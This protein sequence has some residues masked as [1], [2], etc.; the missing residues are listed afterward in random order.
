MDVTGPILLELKTLRHMV[1]FVKQPVVYIE[2][3]DTNSMIQHRLDSQQIK[4][5]E[6]DENQT[7]YQVASEVLKFGE[8]LQ[9]SAEE[10]QL[11]IHKI[12]QAETISYYISEGPEPEYD[13]KEQ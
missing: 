4:K 6:D 7:E 1:I 13:V 12:N 2:T 5:G 10:S 8:T 3:I 11:S 9:P